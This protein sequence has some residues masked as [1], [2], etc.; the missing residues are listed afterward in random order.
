MHLVTEP[1][2][3]E[4]E[5]RS[6]INI[7]DFCDKTG[8]KYEQRINTIWKELPPRETCARPEVIQDKPGY[9]KLAPGHYGCYLAHKNAI[10]A[11]DNTDYDFILIV[12]GDVIVDSDYQELYD[13]LI[14]F[15]K[16]SSIFNYIL[17]KIRHFLY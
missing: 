8:I 7:K 6:I 10:C 14:R 17:T 2:I 3:N 15:N 9:Y 5:I 11:E 4:K 13:A 12:E 16:I 1:E